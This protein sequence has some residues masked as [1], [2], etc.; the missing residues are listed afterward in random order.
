MSLNHTH[1]VFCQIIFL[2]IQIKNYSL[3]SKIVRTQVYY[4]IVKYLYPRLL[5]SQTNKY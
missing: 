5:E 3:Q 2:N 4:C 1:K